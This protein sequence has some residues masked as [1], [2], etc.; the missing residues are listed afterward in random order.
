MMPTF[1][2]SRSLGAVT[3]RPVLGMI[4]MFPSKAVRRMR[5]LSSVAFAGASGRSWRRSPASF[6]FVF[7]LSHGRRYE[8][9]R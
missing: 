8:V 1:H 7:L 5:R 4:T 3:K 9:D 6:A 2:D